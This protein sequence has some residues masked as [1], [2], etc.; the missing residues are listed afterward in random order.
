LTWKSG[1]IPN[2]LTTYTGFSPYTFAG[3]LLFF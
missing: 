1:Q 2:I 3:Y